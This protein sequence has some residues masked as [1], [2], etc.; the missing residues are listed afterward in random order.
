MY[1]AL[2]RK[3]RPRTFKDVI[4]QQHITTTLTNQLKTGQV[5]HAYLFTGSRGTG[6]TSCAKILAKAV[7]C[8]HPVDGNPCLECEACRL[9]DEGASDIYEIDAASNNGVDDV[10]AL[11]D[12][13]MYAPINCKYRVYII[14]EV[15]MLSIAAFN[16]LLKTIEEPPEH[17]V[18]ILATTEIHKVPA[19]ILSRCQ[20][21]E[22]RRIDPDDSA[23][24]LMWVAEQE[25]VT[26]HEDAACL[27][28]RISDGG[29]RDALSLLDQCISVSGDVTVQVVRECAGVAGKEHLFAFTDAVLEKNP[30]AALGIIDGLYQ[31]SK[32]LSR[33]TQ[34]LIEHYRTLMLLS[35]TPD[36]RL[37]RALPDELA[38]YR[39][40]LNGG[41]TLELIMRCLDI[42]T[43]CLEQMGGSRQRKILAEMTAIRLCTPKLDTDVKSLTIR[44]DSLEAFVKKAM[45]G[46]I[47][48]NPQYERQ[49]TAETPPAAPV[50]PADREIPPA[51]AVTA[52]EPM[53]EVPPPAEPIAEAPDMLRP[54]AQWA[55]IIDSLPAFLAGLI[56]NSEGF[57]SGDAILVKGS[58]AVKSILSQKDYNA[59]LGDGIEKALGRR[60]PIVLSEDETPA[61]Q[62]DNRIESFLA[63]A[64]EQGVAIKKK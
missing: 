47:P 5:A 55:E 1:L 33:L 9:I 20:R 30:A 45:D 63:F 7:N 15:H 48:A 10:R 44:M 50:Q 53:E 17:V 36:S 2:Y 26:L 40:Q 64:Q 58:P 62:T 11:R 29:M 13:V 19:T 21:F 56:E 14:D 39:A 43:V 4:S 59:K 27:I 38:Q 18:F 41:Y 12:E 49:I 35:V 42:L 8:L 16:A 34:E 57:Y 51:E 46:Q 22:F 61:E 23:K 3:Y 31:Q 24:R 32:D 28:S 60:Y 54:V 37:I 6:K 52:A 25:K